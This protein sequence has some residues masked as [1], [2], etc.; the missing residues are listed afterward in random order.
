MN[1][2]FCAWLV[3]CP[4]WDA[5][6]GVDFGTVLTVVQALELGLF[7]MIWIGH[8]KSPAGFENGAQIFVARTVVNTKQA[9]SEARQ[10]SLEIRE[11]RNWIYCRLGHSKKKKAGYGLAVLMAAK[12]LRGLALCLIL[13]AKLKLGSKGLWFGCRSPSLRLSLCLCPEL[14]LWAALA[15]SGCSRMVLGVSAAAWLGTISSRSARSRRWK[16]K[17]RKKR[18]KSQGVVPPTAK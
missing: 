14:Q 6:E 18:G 5:L 12:Y 3:D 15:W 13:L 4:K 1:N 16:K 8:P 9:A 11:E 10:L 17:R 7:N 2:L